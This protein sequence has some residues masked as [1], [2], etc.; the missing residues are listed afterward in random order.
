MFFVG[1]NPSPKTEETY[2]PDVTEKDAKLAFSADQ[3][4]DVPAGLRQ[5]PA[6]TFD[7]KP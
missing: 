2:I 5:T 3:W 7:R 1:L 6:R 4:N